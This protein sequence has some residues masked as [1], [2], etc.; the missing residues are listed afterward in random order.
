MSSK[1]GLW[2][3][4][5]LVTIPAFV[6]CSSSDDESGQNDV[7]TQPQTG[8]DASA[9]PQ[10]SSVAEPQ[11][12]AATEDAS[13]MPDASGPVCTAAAEQLLKPVDSVSTGAVTVLSDETG[14]KTIFVDAAAGGTAGQATNP[15]LYLNL[16]SLARVDVTDKTAST[17]TAWD[18]A[19]K[20][21]I[22]FTNGGH[23][24]SGQ[25]GA[26]RLVDK[27]FDAVT[28]ADASSATFA[29]EIF[30]DADCNPQTDQTGAV[31]TTFDGW[32]DYNTADNTLT[33]AAGTWLVKGG[34][35]KLYKIAIVTYYATPDGGV[36]MSGGRYVIKVGA[37]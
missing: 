13:H 24:G 11:K 29:K 22:L 5:S 19:I 2:F 27:E 14:V 35:G 10:D 4:A 1:L 36:G 17:S 8:P 15:R 26:V 23:G 16:D 12:D 9:N 33:P 30:F 31:K 20:R 34:A 6:A 32:Y 3:F 37:L 25:G 28:A 21:P 18:L 7:A